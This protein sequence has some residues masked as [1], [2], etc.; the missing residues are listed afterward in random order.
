VGAKGSPSTNTPSGLSFNK[1]TIYRTKARLINEANG[2]NRQLMA[3]RPF[4][5]K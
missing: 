4:N 2:N 3:L 5:R 1:Y